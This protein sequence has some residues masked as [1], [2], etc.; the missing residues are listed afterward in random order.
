MEFIC[1]RSCLFCTM[2]LLTLKLV[3]FVG[4]FLS[5]ESSLFASS[6][7]APEECSLSLELWSSTCP[8]PAD[9][10]DYDATLLLLPVRKPSSASSYISA[11]TDECLTESSDNRGRRLPGLTRGSTSLILKLKK[12]FPL[13]YFSWVKGDARPSS[14]ESSFSRATGS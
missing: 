10:T 4:F 8:S 12:W 11:P 14:A 9:L 5:S 1:S 3:I 6:T 13:G 7:C 2:A